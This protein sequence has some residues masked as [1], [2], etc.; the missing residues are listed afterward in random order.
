MQRIMTETTTADDD[1]NGCNETNNAIKK[2]HNNMG[3]NNQIRN[4]CKNNRNRKNNVSNTCN[5]C[6]HTTTHRI[7]F[8]IF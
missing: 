2:N 1:M 5:S 8:I 3:D 7:I 4:K 6:N